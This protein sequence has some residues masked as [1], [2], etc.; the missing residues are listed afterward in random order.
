MIIMNYKK[1][2]ML[3]LVNVK[4]VD[5]CS[6]CPPYHVD[7][8]HTSF[9]D[10]LPHIK[11]EADCIWSI[12]DENGTR[13]TGPIY[14]SL[15]EATSKLGMSKDQ[16]LSAFDN[17]AKKMV[18]NGEYVGKL[19]SASSGSSSNNTTTRKTTIRPT[20]TTTRRTT[21]R[22]TTKKITSK[23]VISI[24]NKNPVTTKTVPTTRNVPVSLPSKQ[25][26]PV[27]F[28]PSRVNSVLPAKETPQQQPQQPEQDPAGLGMIP[29]DEIANSTKNVTNEVPKSA[30][31]STLKAAEVPKGVEA[32]KVNEPEGGSKAGVIAAIGLGCCAATG[33]G[34]LF[35]KRKKSN[36]YE[37]MKNSNLMR[38]LSRRR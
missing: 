10:L 14:K 1:K 30:P 34:L 15:S 6:S 25:T 28:V 38:T 17:T 26:T 21:T 33:L 32:P 24:V 36:I 29:V 7:L 3:Y 19:G 22:T 2:K 13:L 20:T 35:I 37:S 16:L 23:I 8:S 31:E 18:R 4:V 12:Y 9:G 11:G 5:S 27:K